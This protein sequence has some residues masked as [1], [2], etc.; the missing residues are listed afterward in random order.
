MS[1]DQDAARALLDDA[2]WSDRD[3]DGVRENAEGD[4]LSISLK[5]SPGLRQDVAEIMQAQL[6]EIG[7]EVTPAVVE[8]N[9]MIGQLLDT[10]R[11]FDGVVMAFTVEFKLDDTDLFH[12]EGIDRGY[13]WSG[14]NRPDIDHYLDRLPLILDRDEARAAWSEYQRLIIDEQPYTFLWFPERRIGKR[15]RLENLTADVRGEWL[16]V[17][18]WWIQAD[19]R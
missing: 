18:D 15:T 1:Y 9:T 14:T 11:D 8:F 10:A 4:R 19:Q 7:V 6:G 5:Y 2:G 16:N 12:S 3:G 17:K 13:A